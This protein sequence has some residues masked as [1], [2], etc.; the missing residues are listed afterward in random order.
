M[1]DARPPYFGDSTVTRLQISAQ[2]TTEHKVQKRSK[3]H[4]CKVC[5]KMFPRPSG[6]ATHMNSHSGAKPFECSVPHCNKKFAVR[7]NAK[8]HLRT[9]GIN[10]SSCD[11]SPPHQQ[12]TVK[13]EES[14]V[15][16][17]DHDFGTTPSK[18]RWM[19]PSQGL[20]TRTGSSVNWLKSVPSMELR[21]GESSSSTYYTR[22][23]TQ[24]GASSS[25]LGSSDGYEDIYSF[26][27]A[28]EYP[29]PA[30]QVG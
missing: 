29:Y 20:A 23:A 6:L 1:R 14:Q 21:Q 9:H 4:Q 5:S 19:P 24:S 18:Y 15:N 2:N 22:L 27:S 10:P 8:R 25:E 30:R 12:Y 13:F 17:E 11:T 3:M 28:E 16:P 7:S 26:A